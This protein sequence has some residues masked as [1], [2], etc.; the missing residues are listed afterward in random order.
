MSDISN[1]SDFRQALQAMDPV[2]QRQVAALF[3]EHVLALCGDKRLDR[4]IET[5]ADVDAT[6]DELAGALKSARATT[7]DHHARC[8]AEGTLVRSGGLFCRP[9]GGCSEYAAGAVEGRGVL[10]GKRP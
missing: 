1:D 6:E 2:Q 10:H 5:V 9:C 7:F 8:G 4:V 3:V